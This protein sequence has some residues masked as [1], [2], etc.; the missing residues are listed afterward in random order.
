MTCREYEARLELL[1]DFL[2]GELRGRAREEVETHLAAC[3][4][5]SELLTDMC[6]A[7]ALLRAALEPA[8]GPSPFFQTRLDGALLTEEARRREASEFWPSLEALAGR[9][10]WLSGAAV[11]VLGAFQLGMEWRLTHPV[12]EAAQAEIREMVPR[13]LELPADQAEVLLSLA[14]N[15]AERGNK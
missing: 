8:A 9:L 4:V 12:P 7:A 3:S 6:R 15:G 13:P 2:S 11:L 14:S 5:C 10:A 1:E